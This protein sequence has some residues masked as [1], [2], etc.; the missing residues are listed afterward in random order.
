MLML[1]T[2]AHLYL[3]IGLLYFVGIAQTYKKPRSNEHFFIDK[4]VFCRY[5]VK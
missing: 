5:T 1:K 2:G 3:C 4:P